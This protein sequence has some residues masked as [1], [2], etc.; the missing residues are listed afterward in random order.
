MKA[1]VLGEKGGDFA[2][3][4]VDRI[5]DFVDLVL[6]AIDAGKSPMEIMSIL[7]DF[8]KTF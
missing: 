7:N 6:D 4:S 3:E 2:T 1:A 8:R 5:T